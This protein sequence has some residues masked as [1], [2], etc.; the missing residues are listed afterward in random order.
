[1][2]VEHRAAEVRK[3][4]EQRR[5][6][7]ERRKGAVEAA[8]RRLKEDFGCG[9]VAAAEKKLRLLEEKA[10]AC[11]REASDALDELE[12]LLDGRP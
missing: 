2:S 4:L 8:L 5:A 11:E 3:R 1:M 10:A 12:G 6:E 7:R 9:T